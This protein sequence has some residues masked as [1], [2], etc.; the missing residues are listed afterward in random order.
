MASKIKKEQFF[1]TVPGSPNRLAFQVTS[2]TSL[3]V[4]WGEPAVTNGKIIG[5]EVKYEPS[6][7]YLVLVSFIILFQRIN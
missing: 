4:S 2:P 5:Y 3:N 7:T 6:G 1:L